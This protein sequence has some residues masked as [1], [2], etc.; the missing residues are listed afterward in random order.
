[1]DFHSF[2]HA[3]DAIRQGERTN[4]REQTCTVRFSPSILMHFSDF[5]S[6]DIIELCKMFSRQVKLTQK[7]NVTAHGNGMAT[8]SVSIRERTSV[9]CYLQRFTA[10]SVLRCI[11]CI[12]PCLKRERMTVMRLISV[13]RWRNSL[14][15]GFISS[16]VFMSS[17]FNSD[18]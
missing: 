1:M 14:T 3:C 11:L 8:L 13:W 16:S 12:M 5:K 9:A 4:M 6:C 15:V 18:V 17:S 2:Q 10:W 7:F